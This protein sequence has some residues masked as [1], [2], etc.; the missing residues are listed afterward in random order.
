M[1][2]TWF[3]A[4]IKQDIAISTQNEHESILPIREDHIAFIQKKAIHKHIYPKATKSISIHRMII[5]SNV[6]ISSLA[7]HGDQRI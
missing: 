3:Q 1:K 6:I 4:Q 5:T 7:Y 2:R